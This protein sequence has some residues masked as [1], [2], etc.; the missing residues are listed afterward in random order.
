MPKKKAPP[1]KTPPKPRDRKTDPD[2]HIRF[3]TFALEHGATDSEALDK[4]MGEIGSQ[5]A[6]PRGEKKS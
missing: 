3:R 2:Q 4:A 6:P 5:K 1:E